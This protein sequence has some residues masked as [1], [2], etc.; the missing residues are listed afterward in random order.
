MRKQL[1]AVVKSDKMTKSA[2]VE[3]NRLKIHPKY[4]KRI[5]LSNTFIVHNEIGA[6]IGDNVLIES[7]RPLSHKKHFQITKIITKK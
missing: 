3:V 1:K 7:T 6:K 4:K 5:R 2:V